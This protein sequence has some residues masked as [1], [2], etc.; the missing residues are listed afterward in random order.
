MAGG[1]REPGP[2]F[3]RGRGEG[4]RTQGAGAVPYP[5]PP[6]RST[7]VRLPTLRLNVSTPPGS[8]APR[9][10][11]RPTVGPGREG[12]QQGRGPDVLGAATPSACVWDS[13]YVPPAGARMPA[14]PPRPHPAFVDPQRGPQVPAG[15]SPGHPT[16]PQAQPATSTPA[17]GPS[18][19][20][21]AGKADTALT[22]F[23]WSDST[24]DQ[25][26][27]EEK[28]G[29]ARKERSG[30]GLPSC[31]Q[32]RSGRRLEQ[33]GNRIAR[34]TLLNALQGVCRN[35]CAF[36]LRHADCQVGFGCPLE[37]VR[38]RASCSGEPGGHGHPLAW[39]RAGHPGSARV[40]LVEGRG[41]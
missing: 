10:G 37:T 1:T 4:E 21:C 18:P 5:P 35:L 28:R 19:P 23:Y 27:S 22:F 32:S 16:M 14:A 9:G 24:D 34:T 38:S 20:V 13:E 7:R 29:R 6:P 40:S 11:A 26:P 2:G 41:L 17:S 31:A 8:P 39:V 36:P 15:G 3:G 33:L 12:H 25:W 30:R